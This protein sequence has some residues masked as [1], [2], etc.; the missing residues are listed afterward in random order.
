MEICGSFR[1]GSSTSGDVD[2]LLTHPD[3]TS[4]SKEYKH[5]T[6]GKTT[7]ATILLD[8]VIESL[9]KVKFIT[10]TIALGD[11]KFMVS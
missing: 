9:K 7:E 8:K 11:F 2:I 6:K 3:Y 4:S 1:R 5:R 10:E